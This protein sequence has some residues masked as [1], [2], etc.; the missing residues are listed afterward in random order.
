MA[1]VTFTVDSI[2]YSTEP[3]ST[4]TTH[5]TK[6][7]IPQKWE[8]ELFRLEGEPFRKAVVMIT[9]LD[10]PDRVYELRFRNRYTGDA[11]AD[12]SDWM[13]SDPDKVTGNVN[14]IEHVR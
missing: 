2:S 14:A 7:G 8:I 9:V 3:I 10:V 1:Q 5:T 11:D 13:I 12:A 6:L 4:N